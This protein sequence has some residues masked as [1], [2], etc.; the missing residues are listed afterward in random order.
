MDKKVTSWNATSQNG[1]SNL[2]VGRSLATRISSFQLRVFPSGSTQGSISIHFGEKSPNG[3]NCTKLEPRW[4]SEL[5]VKELLNKPGGANGGTP[6][7]TF[8]PDGF[9]GKKTPVF[10]K[11]KRSKDPNFPKR[12][13]PYSVQSERSLNTITE[14]LHPF[15]NQWIHQTRQDKWCLVQ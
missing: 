9:W 10:N 2:T 4:V 7:P 3:W 15:G 1:Q 12:N 8:R 11:P 5:P 13:R 6:N 14:S